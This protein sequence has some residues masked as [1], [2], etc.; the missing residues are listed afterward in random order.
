MAQP[1]QQKADAHYTPLENT[2]QNHTNFMRQA[3]K[4]KASI[5]SP[6]VIFQEACL[7]QEG[8]YNPENSRATAY[9]D[10]C[11]LSIAMWSDE[12]DAPKLNQPNLLFY[13]IL[14]F[15]IY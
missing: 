8:L 1:A 4:M 9:C 11:N 3:W 15:H 12:K 13:T 5:Q 7:N 6:I 2:F 14:T 10:S